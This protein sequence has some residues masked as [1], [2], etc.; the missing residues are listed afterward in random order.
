MVKGIGS[1]ILDL[2]D[3]SI[4][5]YI[6]YRIL[7]ILKGT[8]SIQIIGGVFF[9]AVI[10][11][12]SNVAGLKATFWL[13]EKFWVAGVFLLI[14]VFQPE[15][16]NALANL[17][18][19]PF[20]R[21]IVPRD[22]NFIFEITKALKD[23]SSKRIGA[24]IVLEQDMGLADFISSGVIINGEVSS[25]LLISIFSKKSPLHDG[26]VI[27]SNQR[28]IAASCQLPLTERRDISS[29]FG[30]RH[31][32][33]IGIT[34]ITDAIA[35]VVSEENGYVSLARNGNIM[36]KVDLSEIEKDLISLYRSKAQRS[37]FRKGHRR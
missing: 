5:Y 3:V 18:S 33:A 29:A 31:R 14:V 7:L 21:I 8:R 28:I 13:L 27:I 35:M 22:Y 20:G 36:V 12:L 17:G 37:L 16:R 10:T 19:H 25:E 6:V 4:V 34:E 9:L 11:F 32:A 2:F 30:M 1:Y 26:A 24:I 15:I 23:L